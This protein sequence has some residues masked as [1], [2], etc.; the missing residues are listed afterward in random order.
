MRDKVAYLKFTLTIF[1][2]ILFTL[3]G[4][5]C[6][7][8]NF[9]HIY[10]QGNKLSP[11]GIIVVDYSEGW[12]KIFDGLDNMKFFLKSQQGTTYPLTLIQK[13]KS[14]KRHVQFVLKPEHDLPSNKSLSLRLT[15]IDSSNV[16]AI[17]FSHHI[18]KYWKVRAEPDTYAPRFID[19]L[20]VEYDNY[21]NS[22]VKGHGFNCTVLYHDNPVDSF[23]QVKK[24]STELLA[25]V[26]DD[27][28]HSYFIPIQNNLFG[29]HENI[30]WSPFYIPR[31]SEVEFTVRLMDFSGN[32]SQES[33]KFKC[34]TSG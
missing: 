29:I 24:W 32:L 3:R 1:I 27:K 7:I 23:Y 15:G 33:R 30:C 13:T 11:N 6:C 21:I 25:E 5:A 18:R 8:G 20:K 4:I 34:K 17:K 16:N 14:N 19:T 2:T 9:V 12:F 26:T 10:P 31:N 22:S 28:G